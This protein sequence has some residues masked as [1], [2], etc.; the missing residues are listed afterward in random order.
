MFFYWSVFFIK[1]KKKQYIPWTI[2]FLC[3]VELWIHKNMIITCLLSCVAWDPL[4][5]N[6]SLAM[7]EFKAFADENFNVAQMGPF[8]YDRVK[9]IMGKGENAGYQHF[10]SPFLTMFSTLSETEM[11]IFATSNLS[12][13]NVFNFIKTKLLS[14]GKELKWLPWIHRI[15]S[16]FPTMFS[17]GFFFRVVKTLWLFEKVLN[18]FSQSMLHFILTYKPAIEV[19]LINYHYFNYLCFL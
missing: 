13:A 4:P 14:F 19:E 8:Y 12:S 17:K 18:P 9:N 2:W 7:S 1:K 15:A 11:I 6:K 3:T 10:V 5:D 16:P